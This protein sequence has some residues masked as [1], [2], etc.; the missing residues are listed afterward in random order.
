MFIDDPTDLFRPVEAAWEDV[1]QNGDAL[2]R[3]AEAS[4]VE[5]RFSP[6]YDYVPNHPFWRTLDVRDHDPWR[7]RPIRWV[8][9]NAEDSSQWRHGFDAEG[10]VV[11]AGSVLV[12]YGDGFYDMV[13]MHLDRDA[14]EWRAYIGHHRTGFP[15][16]RMNRYLTDTDGRIVTRVTVNNEYE[17]PEHH[18]RDLRQHEWVDSR[19]VRTWRQAFDYGKEIPQW[20][21]D[22][23]EEHIANMY[24]Q[25]TDDLREY[26]ASRNVTVYDYNQEGRLIEVTE[27][28]EETKTV[29]ETRYTYN[30]DDTIEN[31]SE[32]LVQELSKAVI[33]AIGSVK[34]AKP[35]RRVALVY[36]AEHAHCGLPTGILVAGRDDELADQFDWE[37]YSHEAQWP[38]AARTGQKIDS[39]TRRLLLVVEGDPKYADDFQPRPYREVLWKV[40]QNVYASL[41]KK[42]T[43]TDDFAIFPIDDHGDV[44]PAD[45]IRESLPVDVANQL[46]S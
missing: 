38:P 39:L 33:K 29:Q 10:R 7:E 15:A 1:V 23:P 35:A 27:R 42:R 16:G 3:E 5:W 41:A 44:E 37:S 45:D 18:N 2:R 36:S 43:T 17:E 34:E 9:E 31:V 20:A 46:L 25:A 4:V 24:R 21:L 8:P 19:L 28:D 26:N 22:L 40:C 14:N 11:I 12:I 32:A 30:P 13:R 6:E